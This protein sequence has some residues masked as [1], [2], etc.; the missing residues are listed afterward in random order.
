MPQINNIRFQKFDE[1]NNIIFIAKPEHELES[2]DKMHKWYDMLT[3]KFPESFLPIYATTEFSTIRLRGKIQ[4]FEAN[5]T[6]N[7]DFNIKHKKSDDGDKSF[8]NCYLDGVCLVAKA[9]VIDY[10]DDVN[11]ESD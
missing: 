2:Y 8:V 1:F 11:L 4:K 9:R 7:I 10:G 6:Y 3:H 5:A